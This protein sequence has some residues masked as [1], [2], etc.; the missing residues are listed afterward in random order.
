VL[1]YV[2]RFGLPDLS[3]PSPSPT[4]RQ[5]SAA[6]TRPPPTSAG[7][8]PTPAGGATDEPGRSS[9]PATPTPTR[10]PAFRPGRHPDG[11]PARIGDEEVVRPA[12]VAGALSDRS[13][14]VGGWH[15]AGRLF[16]RP[17][18]GDSVLLAGLSSELP[19]GPLVVRG[20]RELGSTT[21]VVEE[22]VWAGDIISDTAPIG[23]G[24][25]V[26]ALIDRFP[27]RDP[28]SLDRVA[29]IEANLRLDCSEGW[30]RHTYYGDTGPVLLL[31]AF[32]SPIDRMLAEPAITQ[33]QY[34]N[35]PP[36]LERRCRPPV[37]TTA[38]T[39]WLV[40]GNVMLLIRG[41]ARNAELARAALAQARA[42]TDRPEP[43][44]QP[45]TEWQA[46]R[47]LWDV[48]P[49]LDVAPPAEEVLC[50]DGLPQQSWSVRH[51]FVRG[52]AFFESVN[53]REAFQAETPASDVRLERGACSGL[54][55]QRPIGADARWVGVGNVLV[56]M[57]APV[58]V[59][60]PIERALLARTLRIRR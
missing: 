13:L 50:A 55:G 1:V 34:P 30:P 53:E 47:A 3:G 2:G 28:S 17:A 56:L 4:D 40:D 45:L 23:V 46:L 22:V 39:R 41:G 16:S 33:S 9:P 18:S 6:P 42:E 10:A 35:A 24:P 36:S 5:A 58:E 15:S 60:G 49:R 14:L 29:L 37:R 48:Y 52:L 21:L 27:A 38:R 12:T 26:A 25:L 43:S 44:W 51:R 31:L 19:A 54:A 59:D 11:I 7:G 32:S 20:A 8:V 57:T